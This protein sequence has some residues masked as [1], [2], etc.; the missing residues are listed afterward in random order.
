MTEPIVKFT[1]VLIGI[2]ILL[3]TLLI[4]L[5]LKIYFV[6]V[7][8]LKNN[9]YHVLMLT[10][11]LTGFT[12]QI[13]QCTIDLTIKEDPSTLGVYRFSLIAGMIFWW[14][15]DL[16]HCIFAMKYWILSRK[17]KGKEKIKTKAQIMFY[18]QL[19]LI[20]LAP[21]LNLWFLWTPGRQYFLIGLGLFF[22]LPAFI[23]VI[24]L[25]ESL[26]TMHKSTIKIS[27]SKK[28][29]LIQLFSN[30]VFAITMPLPFFTE[31]NSNLDYIF[32]SLSLLAQF[33][34]LFVLTQSLST[35]ARF[36]LDHEN[37]NKL[38]DTLTSDIQEDDIGTYK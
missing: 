25:A 23:V 38:D 19:F 18:S 30:L 12:F 10:L 20:F 37:V 6:P 3:Y 33:V 36:Q 7:R 29:V 22:S 26:Y 16:L 21:V 17:L 9:K 28:Q 24:I 1:H 13:I 4:S 14:C 35:Q 32:S 15:D 2:L 34:G 11:L 8:K 5:T 27:L 31:P